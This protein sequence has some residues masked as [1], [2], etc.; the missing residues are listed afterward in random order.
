MRPRLDKKRINTFL[1]GAFFPVNLP[2]QNDTIKKARH[3]FGYQ[4]MVCIRRS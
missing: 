2:C 4:K 1:A 3:G